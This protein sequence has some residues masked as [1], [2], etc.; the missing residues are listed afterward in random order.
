MR[1]H[2]LLS[3]GLICVSILIA[4]QAYFIYHCV[5]KL[6]CLQVSFNRLACLGCHYLLCYSRFR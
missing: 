2:A 5:R 4:N 3:P 1:L 6:F